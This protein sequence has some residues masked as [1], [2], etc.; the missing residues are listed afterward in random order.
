MRR[1]GTFL[2][3]LS[4]PGTLVSKINRLRP[5]ATITML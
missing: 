3:L 5:A 1:P 4:R 2:C